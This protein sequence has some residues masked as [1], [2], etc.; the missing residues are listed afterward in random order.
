MRAIRHGVSRDGDGLWFMPSEVFH[1]MTAEDLGAVIAFVKT[2]PPVDNE[3]PAR[4]ATPLANILVAIGLFGEIVPAQLIDHDA[5]IRDSIAPAITAEYGQYLASIS[6][7]LICHGEDLTGGVH[8][9]PEA[10]KPPNITT[11]GR[12]SG[13]SETD[14]IRLLRSGTTPDNRVIDPDLMPWDMFYTNWTD[15]ELRAV[16][17]SVNSVPAV[18]S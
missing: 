8:P 18:A 12:T 15:D 2:V 3:S 7:C 16:W 10:P 6:H 13:Y 14:F 9:D 4:S 5:P 11:G 17:E 1:N